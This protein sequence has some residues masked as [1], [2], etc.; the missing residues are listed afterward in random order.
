MIWF[1]LA[2]TLQMNQIQFAE[3][4]CAN[5]LGLNH[6]YLDGPGFGTAVCNDSFMF[7]VRPIQSP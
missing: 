1:L 5:H 7:Y 4:N 6:I 2:C 3:D